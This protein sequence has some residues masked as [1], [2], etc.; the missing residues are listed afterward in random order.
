MKP[1][2]VG[3]KAYVNS[4]KS[5]ISM[6]LSSDFENHAVLFDSSRSRSAQVRLSLGFFAL[7]CVFVFCLFLILLKEKKWTGRQKEQET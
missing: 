5:L 3:S 2:H 6:D 7:F 1:N 4:P